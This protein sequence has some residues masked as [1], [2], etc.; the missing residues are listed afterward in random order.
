MTLRCSRCDKRLSRKTAR[1]I[2]GKL[3]CS[4]C[5]FAG[6]KPR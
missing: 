3:L 1:M 2:D 5:M 4:A 6:P